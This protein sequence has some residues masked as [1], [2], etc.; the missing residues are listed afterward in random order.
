MIFELAGGTQ[1]TRDPATAAEWAKAQ[2]FATHPIAQAHKLPVLIQGPTGTGKDA[3]ARAIFVWARK[4]LDD[5][6]AKRSADYL[7][8]NCAALPDSLFESELFGYKKGAY[9][10]AD[11]ASPGAAESVGEGILFLDE[12][13]EL[14]LSS[15]AK[16][17]R[18]LESR[19][20]RGLGELTPRHFAGRCVFATHKDLPAMVAAGAF[21][22]DLYHRIAQAI[23]RT[24][25]LA[26]RPMDVPCILQAIIG[27]L[28]LSARIAPSLS[29]LLSADLTTD[30][31]ALQLWR[32]L[33][34]VCTGNVRHL[35]GAVLRAAIT[36]D[37]P[38]HYGLILSAAAC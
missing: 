33:A 36:S 30:G 16:L 34:E 37:D 26:A 24:H 18:F 5:R 22:E 38:L 19:E 12:I 32:Q 29:A 27:E 6:N 17:L 3:L 20:I 10:G 14:S 2:R 7:A 21:R 13:G 23:V 28:D 11:R 25:A 9:T 8:L 15:Q 4:A 1:R 31:M 35:R